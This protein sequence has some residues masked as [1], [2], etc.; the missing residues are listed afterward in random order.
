MRIIDEIHRQRTILGLKQ[1]NRV[2]LSHSAFQQ[3]LAEEDELGLHQ[4]NTQTIPPTVY[5]MSISITDEPDREV[6]VLAGAPVVG[7]VVPDLIGEAATEEAP[8]LSGSRVLAVE[9]PARGE[10]VRLLVEL[11]RHP[12]KAHVLCAL[13]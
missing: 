8:H 1:A 2:I 3:L 11:E 13:S 7:S 9:E 6:T 12:F 10:V 4:F 5:G